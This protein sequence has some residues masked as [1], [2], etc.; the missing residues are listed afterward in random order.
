MS[1]MRLS[2]RE[3]PNSNDDLTRTLQIHRSCLK[4]HDKLKHIGHSLPDNANSLS[5]VPRKVNNV[6]RRFLL[7]ALLL[8][9]FATNAHSNPR[10]GATVSFDNDWRFHLGD[11]PDGQRVDLNDSNW[12]AL[13]L[14][15]DWSVEGTFDE[16]S[17][18]GK[19]DYHTMGA[20][21]EVLN[22]IA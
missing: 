8:S 1:D 4:S 22:A 13:N 17:P 19:T 10:P 12:R 18:A 2:C 20:C 15:H 16:K 21:Y 7:L 9:F 5:T 11:V 14:P 3:I 6:Y